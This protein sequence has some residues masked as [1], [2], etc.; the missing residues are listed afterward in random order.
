MAMLAGWAVVTGVV[1]RDRR[2]RRGLA[3]VTCASVAV[4]GAALAATLVLPRPAWLA[5]MVGPFGDLV[6]G[7]YVRFQGG[8][9]HPAQL[10]SFLLLAWVLVGLGGSSLPRWA[11]RGARGLI[12][13]LLVFTFS[14]AILAMA[15]LL[16]LTTRQPLPRSLRGVVAGTVVSLIAVLSLLNLRLDPSRPWAAHWSHQPPPRRLA[17]VS[18]L[19]TVV[20]RPLTGRG[21]ESHPGSAWGIPMDAHCTPVNVAATLG[22]PALGALAAVVALVWRQ[23]SRPTDWLLWGALLALGIDG[24]AQ[25]IEDFRHVWLAIGLAAANTQPMGAAGGEAAVPSQVVSPMP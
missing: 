24:L 1:A 20:S 19:E 18:S 12:L 9:T 10:G 5:R 23:R 16:A 11:R 13:I 22:L 17:L 25:D 6:P 7:R 2:V 8:F 4:L 15:V 3:L 21:P 14:R